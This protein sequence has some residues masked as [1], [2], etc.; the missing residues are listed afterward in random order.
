[1][2]TRRHFI[3][4]A[5]PAFLAPAVLSRT[6][7]EVRAEALSQRPSAGEEPRMHVG[8]QQ[9]CSPR[10]LQFY[11]RCG[12]DH[13]CGDPNEWTLEGLLE[14]KDRCSKSGIT[15]DM[16]PIGMPRS[17][18]LLGDSAHRDR[19]IEQTCS[20]IRRVL[21]VGLREMIVVTRYLPLW[22]AYF[23]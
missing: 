9:S 10:M 1:M 15:L 18:G 17:V 12:V 19:Q 20:Q 7:I 14:L 3:N 8:T 23:A 21:S 4:I 5:G 2:F 16:V 13:I 11:K 6:G 22:P